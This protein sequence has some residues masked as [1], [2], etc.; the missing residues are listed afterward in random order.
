MIGCTVVIVLL[1]KDRIISSIQN[2][3]GE[4]NPSENV[5]ACFN[6]EHLEAVND[7]LMVGSEKT[8]SCL[9]LGNSIT[10]TGV[11]DE[12]LNKEKRGLAS[13]RK[14]KDYVHVLVRQI[15]E[16]HHVNVRFSIINVADFERNFLVNSFPFEELSK[17]S[18]Q[19]PD[20]LIVQIGE[21]VSKEDIINSPDRFERAYEELLD[22]FPNSKRIITIPF[23]PDYNKEYLI[24]RVAIK[25]NSYLVDISHVGDGDDSKAFASSCRNYSK[26]GVGEHP[27]DYGMTKIAECI[28]AIFNAIENENNN[29]SN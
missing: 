23:W 6:N 3:F 22:F 9:F 8:I 15:A 29:Y 12:D 7:S 1:Y 20:Y 5:L 21:N 17:A 25:T 28:Y 24:T 27:G 16:E 2:R 26:P 14:E 19:Q 18:N 11:P 4:Q 10:Y 13:T